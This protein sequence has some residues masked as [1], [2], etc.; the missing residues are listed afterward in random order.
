MQ[1]FCT[2]VSSSHIALAK[3]LFS[4]LQKQNSD[5]KLHV[6]IIDENNS[7]STDGFIIHTVNTLSSYR[8]FQKI[9]KKYAAGNKDHFRW[10]L[11]P[12]LIS[13]LLQNGYDKVI[14]ADSDTY[15]VNDFSFL[16]SFLDDSSILL[17][18]H[19]ANTDPWQNEDSLFA[20]LRGGLYNA[21]FIGANKN[22]LDAM[23]WWA[24]MCHYKMDKRKE[25]G[26]HDDQKYLDI[27]PVQFPGV[28]VLK[29]QGCNLASWNIDTCKR[30]IIDGR[31]LINKKYEPVFI[32]FAADTIINILNR[33]DILLKPY[34]D[35]YVERLSKEGYYLLKNMDQKNLYKYNSFAYK[36]KHHLL[37]RTRLKR[38]LYTIAEKL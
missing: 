36:L 22:G 18:P 5:I 19:W 7:V 32:H 21:G 3:A 28:K 12:V 17:S 15:F 2:I 25:L 35:E 13:Y 11:K 10:S 27:L 9:E 31:L 24:E 14:F 6:L 34:L 23:N 20:V 37:L 33:N 26:L 4:S 38:F 1:A 8:L 30:G 16:F 29:H